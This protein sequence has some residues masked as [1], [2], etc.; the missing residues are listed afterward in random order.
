M[1][2]FA[3]RTVAGLVVAVAAL[4][5]RRARARRRRVRRRGAALGQGG[6]PGRAD[7]PR[8][9][10]A[11][12]PTA[13][14]HYVVVAPSEKQS[15][16]LYY[17]DGKTFYRVPLPPWV[18]TRRQL[19]RAALL[20][21]DQE[22]ELPRPRHAHV[23]VGRLRREEGDLQRELRRAQD[24][25]DDPGRGREEGAAAGQGDVRAAAAQAR[26]APP[27]ARRRAAATSTSTRATPPDTEKN[28]R[29]FVGPKG[30]MKL[31]KM[32]NAVADTEGEIFTTKIG[33]AP[34]RDRPQEP[35][36]LDPG[37]EEADADR[38][39][40]RGH[41]REDRRADQQLP[42]HLQRAGRV[43]RR[44]ARQPL[45]RSRRR[46][47]RTPLPNPLPASRGEGRRGS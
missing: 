36:G 16:Q 31:Q 5:A 45:R 12:A 25:P 43:P 10:R 20:R 15:T 9:D 34:L 26:A 29:L 38:R 42:A 41:R 22:L 28:F 6:E 46:P 32:T 27:G 33:L 19:L 2:W 11:S 47:A 17:G 35:A 13:R 23:R 24:R 8:E 14:S 18:L 3:L 40:D 39:P 7:D 4:L 37:K 44:E 30:A 21:E 1:K